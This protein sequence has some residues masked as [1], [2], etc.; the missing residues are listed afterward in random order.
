M[1][2]IRMFARRHAVA[3]L[4]AA[5]VLAGHVQAKEAAE[6]LAEARSFLHHQVRSMVGCLK[7]VGAGTWEVGQVAKA[8]AAKDRAKLGLNAP[9][10][11]LYFVEAIYPDEA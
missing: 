6:Y 5:L 1:R 10:H 11:G 7:L 4:L 8:L 9:P 3:S 2:S